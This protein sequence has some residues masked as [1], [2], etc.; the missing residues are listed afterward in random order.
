[1][2]VIYK[3]QSDIPYCLHDMRVY[4]I[5]QINDEV[6]FYFE[7]GYIELKEPFQQVDGNIILE[8]VDYDFSYVHFLSKNG[9]FGN[10]I[11]KKMELLD[12]LKEYPD[13]SFEVLD[14]LY[15]Y[16]QVNYSGYLSLPN[17]ENLIDMSITIYYTGNIVYEIKDSV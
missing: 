11:G 16:N 3:F 6:K 7:N 4:R 2:N 15:G 14:E 9:E 17:Q 10:F 13:F 5:E 8:G 1:M 12:F